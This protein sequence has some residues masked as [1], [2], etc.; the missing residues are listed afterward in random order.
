MVLSPYATDPSLTMSPIS[1]FRTELT[2]LK[3]SRE[4]MNEED[5]SEACAQ[6]LSRLEV[7]VAQ[8]SAPLDAGQSLEIVNLLRDS[9][10][11]P[12]MKQRY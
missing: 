12:T 4:H 11:P 5:F 2:L 9:I 7:V 6:S 3:C 10:V 8:N 1:E